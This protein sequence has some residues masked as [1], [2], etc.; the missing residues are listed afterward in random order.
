MKYKSKRIRFISMIVDLIC[1]VVAIPFVVIGKILDI[2]DT[3]T[4]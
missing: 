1:Y 3:A 4:R 2:A